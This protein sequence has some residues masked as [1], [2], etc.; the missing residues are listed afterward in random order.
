[1]SWKKVENLIKFVGYHCQFH[2]IIKNIYTDFNNSE[3]Q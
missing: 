3:H 2:D 1:M